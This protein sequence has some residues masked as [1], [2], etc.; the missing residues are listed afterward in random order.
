M[1]TGSEVQLAVKA[2]KALR[3]QGHEVSVV[4]MPSLELFELQSEE[5]KQSVL[6]KE[7][8][9][10]VAVEMGSPFGWDRYIGFEGKT[11]TLNRFG[12]S[13]KGEEVVEHLGFTVEN[14]VA[15]Y[16]ELVE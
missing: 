13:G 7:I 3:E 6:P 8:T 2:Q 5:Y 15:T 14:V 16:L 10:R 9:K 12:A 4:S 11:V 1:A